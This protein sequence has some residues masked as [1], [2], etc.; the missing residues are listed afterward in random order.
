MEELLNENFHISNEQKAKF[1]I[2]LFNLF[3]LW[4]IV[5]SKMWDDEQ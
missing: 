5:T 2:G 3:L 4:H 1:A